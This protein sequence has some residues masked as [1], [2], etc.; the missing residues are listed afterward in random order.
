MIRVV[1]DTN[2]LFSAAFKRVGVPA[3]ILDL[4]APGTLT[5]CISDAI[6]DEYLDVLTRP[7]LRPHAARARE[8]LE[9][10]AKFAVHV[11][12]THKLSLYSD[13]DDNCFLECALAAEAAYI[14][15]GNARHFPK[16]CGSIAIVTP[17]QLLQRL[18]AHQH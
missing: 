5:P 3:Q 7:V 1:F 10:M 16:D 18:I 13:P 6:M 14:V 11:S 8:V 9:L 17:R 2:I 15:T 4:V 12:P